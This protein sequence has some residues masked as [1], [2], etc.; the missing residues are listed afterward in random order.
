MPDEDFMPTVWLKELVDCRGYILF[1]NKEGP[2]DGKRS[3]I[4]LNT[5]DFK[6]MIAMEKGSRSKKERQWQRNITDTHSKFVKFINEI[7]G[8][9]NFKF[10]PRFALKPNLLVCE[11]GCH[12]QGAHTDYVL[13]YI[14]DFIRE[15]LRDF[16]G[17]R[18]VGSVMWAVQNGTKLEVWPNSDAAINDPNWH[19]PI[20][21][22][23]IHVDT[24]SLVEWAGDLVH[25]GSDY[26]K[27]HCRIH[28]FLHDN[29]NSDTL[30]D[31]A[32]MLVSGMDERI[33]DVI[34]E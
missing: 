1:N 22:E 21:R 15:T 18:K 25:A 26:D 33:Q 17:G 19:Q 16:K 27:E 7:T 23:T 5:S 30:P 4:P 32:T 11:P 9:L 6:S 13:E 2:N 29:N 8:M 3:Q 28:W 24:G 34:K 14:Q 20:Q 31:N 10:A 12:R